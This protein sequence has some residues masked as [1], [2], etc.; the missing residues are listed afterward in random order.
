MSNAFVCEIG[1]VFYLKTDKINSPLPHYFICVAKSADEILFLSC[2]TSQGEKQRAFILK[3]G[4]PSNGLVVIE[5]S[6]DN[7]FTKTSFVA[8][9][10]PLT[11]IP[12]EW[13]K[14]EV[15]AGKATRKQSLNEAK[16]KEIATELA[17]S[18]RLPVSIQRL[19]RAQHNL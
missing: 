2:V 1:D 6:P 19:I 5:P 12:L 8:C 7:D 4:L 13:L 10:N 15:E 14:A 9:Y 11:E 18:T 17:R 16:L 3:E